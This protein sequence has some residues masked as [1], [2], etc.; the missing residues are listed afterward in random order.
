M[1]RFTV[2]LRKNDLIPY[3]WLINQNGASLNKFK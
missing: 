3:F 1:D 2:F